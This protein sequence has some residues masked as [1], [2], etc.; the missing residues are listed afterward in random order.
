[1]LR[2]PAH[3]KDVKVSQAELRRVANLMNMAGRQ[4]GRDGDE[5]PFRA[6]AGET[7]IIARQLEYIRQKTTD[8]VYAENK[9][10]QFIPIATDIPDGARSFIVQQW[11][12]AGQAKIV[13]NYAD[14][15]PRV[16]LLAKERS[17]MVHTIGNSYDYTIDELKASAFSGVPL[18][19]KKADAARRIHENTVDQILA[20]GDSDADLPG[21]LNNPNVTIVTPD[22]GN[23]DDP[24]TTPDQR[25]K[26]LNKL[27]WTPRRVSK[28]IFI[29]DTVLLGTNEF[30]DVSTTMYIGPDGSS[31]GKTVLQVFKDANPGVTVDVWHKLDM[32][33]E[34][35]DGP[36]MVAYMRDPLVV[37]GVLPRR[38]TVEPAQARNLT[39]V[40]NCHSS[41]GGTQ[42]NYPLGVAYMDGI[43]D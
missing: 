4:M 35:G 37:E 30:E 5:G 27:L 1:M 15:L 42:V 38:F 10:L 17:Q 26:D 29:A 21:F 32:A 7:A 31:T 36:R 39:W 20:L 24:N 18:Q 22:F 40:N 43:N 28:G 16:E 19:A 11:D 13:S 9:A 2:M 23:W 12:M 6:D 25:L 3:L 34:Q 8:V 33:D 14:D 41:I